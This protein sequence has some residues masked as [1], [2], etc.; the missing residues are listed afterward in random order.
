MTMIKLDLAMLGFYPFYFTCDNIYND[1]Q[2][3][4]GPD[5]SR[6]TRACVSPGVADD[7]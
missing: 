2:V 7:G 6:V 1:I 3:D 4:G 5:S